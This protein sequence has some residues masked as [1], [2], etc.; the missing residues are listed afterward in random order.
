MFKFL[1]W[2]FVFAV[3]AMPTQAETITLL[4]ESV[5]DSAS[6][7]FKSG[8]GVVVEDGVIIKVG[9]QNSLGSSDRV[10]NLDGLFL[11]PGLI[12]NHSHV[13]LH[14]YDET[15]WNDQVLKES[16]AE[17]AIRGAKHARANLMAGFT[18]LRDLGSEGAGYVDVGVRDSI[19]K[20]VIP[21]PRLLV[22]GK[23]IVATGSYGPKG[24]APHFKP[25]LGAE[26][27]DGDTLIK[28]T[29]DQIG[30]GIDWVKVYADYRWGPNGEARPTF[31]VDELKTIVAVAAS[32]GRYTV[33]HASS[34]E[35]MRRATLAGVRTIEHGDGGTL[36]TFKLMAER[37]VAWCPTLSSSEAI[38]GY[39]GWVK[40]I[41]TPPNRVTEQHGAFERALEAG[42]I[43]CMG[44]DIGV[45]DHGDNVFEMELM[46]EY[47]MSAKDVLN[48]AT[49]VNAE[50]LGMSD[51]IGAIKVGLE[52]D[53]IAVSGNPHQDISNLKNVSFVMKEGKI[54]KQP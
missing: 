33:A 31:S 54:Y 41:G 27:A 17:R 49:N 39:G 37:G 36:E 21:G 43:M 22:A 11:I 42:V 14:P 10:Q 44:S 26:E 19:N 6:G 52:A 47:G 15:G 1:S 23:A 3:I 5:L 30:H 50:I 53:L 34:D 18:T 7:T 29:R 16:F 2:L 32:S 45:Y 9:P 35:A 20:G 12:E 25:P 40:G 48:S 24:F 38:A 51:K 13:L 4:P 46:V 8:W 28:V